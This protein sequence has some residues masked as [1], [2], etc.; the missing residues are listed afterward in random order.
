MNRPT[1]Q[2]LVYLVAVA[3]HGHFGRAADACFVSQPALSTQIRE[4]ERRIGATLIERSPRGLLLTP[5][6]A[7]VVDRAR[8]IVR[9][10]EELVEVSAANGVGIVGPLHIGVIPTL[11]PYLLPAVVAA[12][13]N[14]HPQ[15]ELQ[16]SE[17]QTDPLLVELRSGAVDLA[18]LATEVDGTDVETGVLGDDPFVVALAASHPLAAG[19]GVLQLGDVAKLRVLLLADGN[20]LREQAQAVCLDS[21]LVVSDLQGTSLTTVVQM[22]AAGQGITLL[23]SIAAALE[24]RPDSGIVTRPLAAPV[25]RRTIRLAWR[26]RSPRAA[27][28]RELVELLA[29][30]VPDC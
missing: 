6:G 21:S 3:E 10:V 26:A 24:A 25:P 27:R 20:C 28:Y 13:H 22:V 9:D 4:L 17:L 8:A 15:A 7:E 2:Q 30:L 16:L 23:P 29:P 14:A 5:V 12:T 11:S 1:V 19:D 18:L